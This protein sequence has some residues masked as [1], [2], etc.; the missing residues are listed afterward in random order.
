MEIRH[1]VHA[2]VAAVR[3]GIGLNDSELR[4]TKCDDTFDVDARFE[5][6]NGSVVFRVVGVFNPETAKYHCYVTTLGAE[7]WT[8]D[9]LTVLYA[10]RWMVE[11]LFKLLKSS[12]HLDHLDTGDVDALRTHIYASLLASTILSSM[13]HAAAEVHGIPS[14]EISPLTAGIAA[15]LL[16]M[17]LMFLW[18]DRPLT[19]EELSD[20]ILRVLAIGC[21]DQNPRRTRAKWELLSHSQN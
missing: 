4:F 2:P 14:D 3:A 5:T 20:T 16:I 13:C 7:D 8:P 11:L 9:E 15:P 21:R 10:R 19:P 1:G 18:N 6:K 12:C 17:P